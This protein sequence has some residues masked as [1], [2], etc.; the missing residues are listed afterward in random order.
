MYC[1]GRTVSGKN[2]IFFYP[3]I[4]KPCPNVGLEEESSISKM[5]SFLVQLKW[6]SLV[7]LT[8]MPC[9]QIQSQDMSSAARGSTRLKNMNPASGHLM[10][11]IHL[12]RGDHCYGRNCCWNLSSW[13]RDLPG[14]PQ[15]A[16]PRT[17]H[18]WWVLQRSLTEQTIWKGL[19]SRSN[20]TPWD[21]WHQNLVAVKHLPQQN[22]SSV[23]ALFTA[24]FQA[25]PH[26]LINHQY[27][28]KVILLMYSISSFY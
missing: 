11:L 15:C 26:L 12:L 28:L 16:Q 10:L 25:N 24:C 9:L 23:M 3:W 21:L 4:H 8:A 13:Q 14:A 18:C 6:N 2:P 7:L 19:A 22:C 5:A 17:P 20:V 27:I 1:M